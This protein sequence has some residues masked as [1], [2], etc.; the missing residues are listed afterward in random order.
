MLARRFNGGEKSGENKSPQGTTESILAK[1]FNAMAFQYPLKLLG[2][3]HLR[4]MPLLIQ[5]V[6]DGTLKLGNANSESAIRI[7]PSE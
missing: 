2:R 4:V 6:I 3:I 1:A 7:L 5:N